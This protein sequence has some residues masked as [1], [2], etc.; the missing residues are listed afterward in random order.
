MAEDPSKVTQDP[1][2]MYQAPNGGLRLF[3]Y[4]D[5]DLSVGF[6]AAGLVKER[7]DA[8]RL[9][10]YFDGIISG[11]KSNL[12][13]ITM[14]LAGKA[15][16]KL[17]VLNDLVLF[18]QYQQKNLS[19]EGK[20]VLAFG[21]AQLGDSARARTLLDEVIAKFTQKEGQAIF[22]NISKDMES[23][24]QLTGLAA[25]TAALIDHESALALLK[26]TQQFVPTTNT[27]AIEQIIAIDAFLK[28]GAPVQKGSLKYDIAG[29]GDSVSIERAETITISVSPDELKNLHVTSVEGPMAIAATYDIALSQAPES[30]T[31]TLSISRVYEQNGKEA[32]VLQEGS[33]VKVIL[34]PRI[35]EKLKGGIDI[36]DTLPA[37]LLP[38]TTLSYNPYDYGSK[39]IPL[40]Y[41]TRID[42]Q[43]VVIHVNDYGYRSISYLARV[44]SKGT[45]VVE[46]VVIQSS[47]DPTRRS[48]STFGTIEIK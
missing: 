42:G 11:A 25:A 6:K 44:V 38:V 12:D 19:T 2:L 9:E 23:N 26:A 14:A 32:K 16:L 8:S 43:R 33:I 10:Q 29:D 48:I 28:R 15:A 21:F 36:I 4:G 46:P 39:A 17:P 35:Q 40:Y 41:P 47:A 30:N 5:A 1:L 24:K 7:I 22:L 27:N 31:S 18:Q 34:L 3:L 13:E 37:G 20:L 45:Y